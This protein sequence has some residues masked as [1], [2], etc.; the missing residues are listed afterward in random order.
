MQTLK[1]LSIKAICENSNSAADFFEYSPLPW[2]ITREIIRKFPNYKWLYINNLAQNNQNRKRKSLKLIHLSKIIY[3]SER[4]ALLTFTYND[5][6]DQ[7][8]FE[9]GEDCVCLW[10]NYYKLKNYNIK[11]CKSCF[12]NFKF[13]HKYL[14]KYLIAVRDHY[15]NECRT[16]LL[17]TKVYQNK[18]FWC[19]SCFAEV[20][21]IIKYKDDCVNNLHEDKEISKRR[22][23]TDVNDTDDD[24]DISEDD[25]EKF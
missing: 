9:E 1:E 11:I 17:I 6:E 5:W 12:D 3:P 19:N 7:N 23:F 24:I 18:S 22:R 8:I 16:D 4:N 20:L 14:K 10:V 2:T 21:F 15:H 13:S 25:F